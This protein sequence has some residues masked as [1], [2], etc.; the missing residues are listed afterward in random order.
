MRE[1]LC[2]RQVALASPQLLFGPF[3]LGDVHHGTHE[4]DQIAG[5]AE[6]RMA[7]SVDI[8][9]LAAGMNDSVIQLELRLLAPRCLGCFPNL[10]LIVRMNA[11]KECFESR[12]S[13]VPLQTHHPLPFLA[14]VPILPPTT[15]PAPRPP[16]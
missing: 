6:N 12:V 8:S 9:N 16:P 11:L 13:T 15:N 7:H 1:P 10:G 14:P 2:F 5:W 3:A 4:F